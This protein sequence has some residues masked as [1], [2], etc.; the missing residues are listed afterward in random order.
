MTFEYPRQVGSRF[1]IVWIFH[2]SSSASFPLSS[3]VMPSTGARRLS[4]TSCARN[5]SRLF[6]FTVTLCSCLISALLLTSFP[7]SPPFHKIFHCFV[8][9]LVLYRVEC[10]NSK[11]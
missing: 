7:H 6:L 11:S 10:S 4:P 8:F 3:Y 9:V 1:G 5:C 2:F